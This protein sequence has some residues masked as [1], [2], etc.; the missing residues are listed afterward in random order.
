M[1]RK[2]FETLTE[3]MYYVLL[4]LQQP[5]HGYAVMRYAADLT[6]GRVKIGAGTLYTL[7][8]RFEEE[9][10]IAL[11]PVQEGGR[12]C[13]RLT[14]AGELLLWGE[15]QRLKRLVE[16]GERLIKKDQKLPDGR[17]ILDGRL[18]GKGE[19]P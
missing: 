10:Y 17:M 3:Q 9:G 18:L 14:E 19:R 15:F 1:A 12:K 6:G 8:G 7:L 13:Y 11:C 4:S 2:Q 16:D 5:R